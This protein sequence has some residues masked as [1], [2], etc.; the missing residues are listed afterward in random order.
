[1][2]PLRKIETELRRLGYARAVIIRDYSFADVLSVGAEPRRV[3]LAA[4][5]QIPESYRSAAF[6][7]VVQEDER[8]LLEHRS[9]GTPILFSIGQHDIGVWRVN[10]QGAPRTAQARQR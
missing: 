10:A 5:T 1:M 6:G 3:E 2:T 7:V 4:F 8:T 9:L